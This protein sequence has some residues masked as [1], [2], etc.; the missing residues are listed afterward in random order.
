MPKTGLENEKKKMNNFF[1]FLHIPAALF[2]KCF[3]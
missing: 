1:P 3:P 2:I